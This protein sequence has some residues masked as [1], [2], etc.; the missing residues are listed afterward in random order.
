MICSCVFVI[1]FVGELAEDYP[2]GTEPPSRECPNGTECRIGE[3]WKGPNYGITNFDNILF[4]ILTVFQCITMEGW[5]DILY[6]VSS[7]DITRPLQ[8]TDSVCVFISGAVM[9]ALRSVSGCLPLSVVL[10]WLLKSAEGPT[11]STSNKIL[12]MHEKKKRWSFRLWDNIPQ[13]RDVF[14]FSAV[15]YLK[16][17]EVAGELQ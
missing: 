1:I 3:A 6:N 7:M 9:H 15:K 2:C 10:D 17:G 4:A 12:N 16:G 13:N 5:T 8:N 14:L 11:V